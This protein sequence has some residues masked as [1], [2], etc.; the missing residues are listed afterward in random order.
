MNNKTKAAINTFS[1]LV[2]IFTAEPINVAVNSIVIFD[3]LKQLVSKNKELL[4]TIQNYLSKNF[5]TNSSHFTISFTLL[6][7][8]P[9]TISLFDMEGKLIQVLKEGMFESG[10]QSFIWDSGDMPQG[11]YLLQLTADGKTETEK[12]LISR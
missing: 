8:S 2:N 12:I 9:V 5:S 10:E 6:K 4:K 11:A 1:N 3:F 7:E